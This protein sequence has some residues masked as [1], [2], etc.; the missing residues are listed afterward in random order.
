M[1]IQM[2]TLSIADPS[3]S[4]TCLENPPQNSTIMYRPE[5]SRMPSRGG[6]A[7]EPVLRKEAPH[8]TSSSLIGTSLVRLPCSDVCGVSGRQSQVQ[9]QGVV[10]R[11][12][13]FKDS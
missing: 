4:K 13:F 5:L 11:A 2:H 1:R 12:P 9:L 6:Y 7:P 10:S 8:F 3:E